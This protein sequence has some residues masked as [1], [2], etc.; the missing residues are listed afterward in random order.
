M[1]V[2]CCGRDASPRRGRQACPTSCS[3]SDGHLPFGAVVPCPSW[4]D[5]TPAARSTPAVIDIRI[6]DIDGRGPAKA[7]MQAAFV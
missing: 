3:V 7:E 1:R 2:G 5:I 6:N 4:W